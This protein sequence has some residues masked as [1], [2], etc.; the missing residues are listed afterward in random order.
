LDDPCWRIELLGGLRAVGKPGTIARFRTQKT[1]ALL[2]Y[3]AYH[4]GREHSR[5]VLTEILWPEDPHDAAR[6][7]LNVALSSLRAQLEPPG[8]PDG[9]VLLT[10][11]LGVALAAEAVT[12]DVAELEAA[13]A[14]AGATE[15]AEDRAAAL[16]RAADLYAGRLLAGYYEEWILPEQQ[17]LEERY[18]RA[19]LELV[20]LLRDGGRPDDAMQYA[21]AATGIDPLR[22]E[23]HR[24]VIG[25]YFALGH[26]DAAHRQYR[27]LEAGLADALG[28]RPSA[29][30]RALVEQGETPARGPSG[31]VPAPGAVAAAPDE[32]ATGPQELETTG[33]A[34]PLGSRFYVARP[35]DEQCRAAVVRRESIVLIKGASQVGKT[36]LLAR[37]LHQAREAGAGV[38][39]T[40]F[41]LLNVER[42][43]SAR[44]LLETLGAMAADQLD[45]PPPDGAWAEFGGP[46]LAFSR[47]LRQG[48]LAR[49]E[50]PVVWGMDGVDRLFGCPFGGEIFELF[51]SWHNERAFDPDG[52]WSRLTL[53][54]A[55]A[56]E[57]HLFITDP[58]RS[59]FNVGT[60]LFLE[61]FT[62]E[63][64]RDLN[65]RYGS[66]LHSPEEVGR[67]HRLVGGH[68]YL[69]RRGLH[70]QAS[71][72]TD[73]AG[74]EAQAHRDEW[75]FGDHLRR[76]R[77]LVAQDPL[78][79]TA[80]VEV[81]HGRACPTAESFYR[82]RSA[83]VLTGPAEEVARL[84]CPLYE[85][86][87][88]RHLT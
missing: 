52:P 51:R 30:T 43:T 31:P 27:A 22:E 80:V 1:G 15:S 16:S 10:R 76:V 8:V 63:Q 13:L 75:I 59:P 42:L 2:G 84:R 6:H 65:A 21:L 18:F 58:N 32:R 60:R 47:H 74:I 68:P 38:V 73:L 17:R 77:A 34:V 72:G 46:N 50:S 5:E 64:V 67:F 12:T 61:D 44:V 83:G 9:A 20:R 40:D 7:K 33:G 11:R 78:L 71:G 49:T 19:V 26:P 36:S 35:A 86:Y 88:R 55:F 62:P 28:A 87:L 41:R 24:E 69:V 85:A 82:L 25:L 23:V 39:R 45:L 48:I 14:R 57:A 81:L 29:A 66:P 70:E 56:A 53:V 3:L 54:I 37:A 4:R 79:Q